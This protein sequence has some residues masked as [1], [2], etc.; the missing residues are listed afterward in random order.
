M[1]VPDKEK[2]DLFFYLD[3]AINGIYNQLAELRKQIKFYTEQKQKLQRIR[4]AIK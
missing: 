1:K 3:N 4:K 2:E